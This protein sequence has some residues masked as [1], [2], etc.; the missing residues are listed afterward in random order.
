MSTTY[1]SLSV[2]SIRELGTSRAVLLGY[3]K[4]KWMQEAERLRLDFDGWFAVRADEVEKD[5]GIIPQRLIRLLKTLEK[6]K[7][8]KTARKGYPSR[9]LVC[10]V[11][12]K[13][14]P[15]TT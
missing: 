13:G 12:K 4:N 3:L 5:I 1:L 8:I 10:L 6:E 15:I 2:S 7:Y 11:N 9:R 14:V